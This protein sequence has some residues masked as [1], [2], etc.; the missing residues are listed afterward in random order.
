MLLSR[1]TNFFCQVRW[2]DSV[3]TQS[4][5]L[6]RFV[7]LVFSFVAGH[8]SVLQRVTAFLAQLDQIEVQQRSSLS[9]QFQLLQESKAKSQILTT[10]KQQLALKGSLPRR[11]LFWLVLG[12]P[13]ILAVR[14][15]NTTL[16]RLDQSALLN[17]SVGDALLGA[18]AVDDAACA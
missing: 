3:V 10:L 1:L 9:A 16:F 18:C 4:R 17:V 15:L 5:S 7:F 12:Q 8:V 11:R 14:D 13:R 6:D 2:I